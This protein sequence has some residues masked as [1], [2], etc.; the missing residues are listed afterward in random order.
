MPTATHPPAL[1]EGFIWLEST[2]IDDTRHGPGSACWDRD[3]RHDNELG[4]VFIY[5]GTGPVLAYRTERIAE[6]LN[7]GRLK[8]V[9]AP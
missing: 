9:A 1:K 5:T 4:E 6:A 7:A 3:E 2:G 8:I